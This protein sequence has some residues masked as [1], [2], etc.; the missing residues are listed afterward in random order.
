[1]GDMPGS[2]D[3]PLYLLDAASR[4]ERRLLTAWVR[5]QRGDSFRPDE[6]IDLP[7]SRRGR[8]AALGPA[9]EIALSRE[10]DPE[11]TPL[12][13]A[14]I[15]PL[16]DGER[17][18]RLSD[19]LRLGDPRDPTR[20]RQL[21]IHRRDPD[22]ARVVQGEP[23]RLSALRTRWRKAGGVD[24]AGLA[25]FVARQ[26]ALALE[27]SERQ[28]RG[29]RYK[30][31]RF[32]REEILQRPDF[33]AGL[34]VLS[35]ADGRSVDVLAR[36]AGK[37]LRE[38]SATHSR[39]V[40]D[41]AAHLIRR[42]YRRGYGRL[43][44]DE[45]EIAN[46]A[47]IAQRD[48]VVFLPTHKSNLDH[49]VLQY[50]LHEYGL[51]PNHTAGGINM[52][53]F[54]IGQLVRRSG[55]FFIRRTFKDDELYKHVLR[56]YIDYL[57]EKRFPLEWYIEGGRSRSGKLLPP[58]FGMLAY[59]AD[60]FR[61][62]R[63]DDVVLIPV[64]IAYDQIIDVGSYS[65]EQRGGAKTRESF[66]WFI[67]LLRSIGSGYGDI[68]IRFGDALSLRETLG[69][70]DRDAAP[71]PDERSLEL[72]KIAFEVAVRINRATP[73]TPTSVITLAMLGVGD[74][75]LSVAEVRGAMHNLLRYIE[76]RNL[77]TTFEIDS[78][79]EDDG[80]RSAL[81]ALVETDVVARYDEGDEPIYQIGDDQELTAAYYRNCVVHFFVA[82]AIVEL[83]LLQAA[84]PEAVDPTGEFWEEAMRLR[85][86]LKFEFFFPEKAI[87]LDELRE[88]LDFQ[89]EKWEER[90]AKGGESVQQ[91]VQRLRPFC[92][93]RVL[94]P[95]LEA[96][97][98]VADHLARQPTDREIDEEGFV[99]ACLGLGEQYRLQR[100]IHSA[101]SISKVLFQSALEL[102]RNRELL[103]T[104][105]AELSERRRAFA[106]EIR[107][108]VR[109]VETI[110]AFGAARR[111]G[112]PG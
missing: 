12:R 64:S 2:A 75:A 81:D 93:H 46:V 65:R 70:P 11:L 56:S 97:Q 17:A 39:F 3:S 22:R 19:L 13:I 15:P 69:E 58:R 80:V 26:A 9:L 7:A 50:A 54:P 98:L 102:A 60:A 95:F 27:R 61:R 14:W 35:R 89:D 59:V 87:F 21:W 40:I 101:E 42:L 67:G 107:D 8:S 28:L 53:F 45:A 20:L 112:W 103:E 74:R 110:A 109:R 85:D 57:I 84:R 16:R 6:M 79:R 5:E 38:M 10:D 88:E 90:L 83:A 34:V 48:P 82:G 51:P 36:E 30:V 76:L 92:A 86:L 99:T 105:G 106:D 23:A 37:I 41:L 31:P 18:A 43:I 55:V 72:Q 1:M 73:F 91:L 24:T 32:V 49:L 47:R 62:A 66:G 68:H 44:Y 25:D 94:R 4:L 29:A 111:S 52:N 108:A 63:S 96:Y 104:G 78:L 33:R 71:N 100:R 77:P